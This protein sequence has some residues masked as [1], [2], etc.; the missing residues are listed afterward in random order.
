[1][2]RRVLLAAAPAAAGTALARP[3]RAQGWS[4]DRPIR[5]V[6]PFPP[7]GATDVWA[8]IAA[9]GMQGPL[10]QPIVIENRPGAGGMLG[11]EAVARATPDG[12]TLLFTIT[13]LVQSPVVM[14]RFPYDPVRDFQPIGRLG[15]GA[16]VWCVGPAVPASVATMEEFVAWGRGR[17]LSFGSW[18]NGSSGHAF[19]LMLGEEAG[20]RLTHV[21]YRG[22]APCLHDLLAGSIHAAWHTT[23]TAGEVIRGR[24]IR[25]LVSSGARRLPSLPEVRTIR[26]AGFSDRFVFDGFSGLFGPRGL[27]EQVTLRLAEAFAAVARDPE[28]HRR[29]LAMDT[30]PGYLG[31]E[32]FRLF[33]ADALARWQAISDRL[34][35]VAD[36]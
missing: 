12:H 8:R 33:V 1:M 4:P 32:E 14:R 18:A 29:L 23:A 13:S 22:E 7:G 34:G 26:E 30:F 28:T 19:G 20:L 17:D 16:T 5:F 6:V 36:G 3:A 9:E 11:A 2:Q 35:L 15:N 24:R 21:A 27:P 31:P 10:G 25:P